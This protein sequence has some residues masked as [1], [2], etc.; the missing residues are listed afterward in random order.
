M[1]NVI[2][3]LPKDMD[4]HEIKALEKIICELHNINIKPCKH[5]KERMAERGISLEAVKEVYKYATINHVVETNVKEHRG[6]PLLRLL[7]VGNKIYGHG[8]DA[9]KVT[10][11]VNSETYEVVTVVKSFVNKTYGEFVKKSNIDITDYIK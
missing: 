2:R 5:A 9:Y 6:K 3:K 4:N 11:S 1:N 10:V 7:I 8:E